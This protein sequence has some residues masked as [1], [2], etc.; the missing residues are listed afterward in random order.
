MAVMGIDGKRER[1]VGKDGEPYL[2]SDWS[3]GFESVHVDTS[4]RWNLGG[5]SL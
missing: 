2:G 5:I 4:N 1:F 3:K